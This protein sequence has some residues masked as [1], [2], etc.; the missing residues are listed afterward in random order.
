M[1][2]KTCCADIGFFLSMPRIKKRPVSSWKCMIPWAFMFCLRDVL[3]VVMFTVL[4]GDAN[5]NASWWKIN[6]AFKYIILDKGM[7]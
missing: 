5:G 3:H 1:A 2:S 6:I 7:T 4:C